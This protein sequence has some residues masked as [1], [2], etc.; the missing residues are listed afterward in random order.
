M[1]W[2]KSERREDPFSVL[3]LFAYTG[4][5]TIACGCRRGKRLPCGRGKGYG[6]LGKGKRAS[7]SGLEDTAHSLDCRRLRQICRAGDPPGAGATTRSSWTRRAMEEVRPARCGSSKKNLYPFVE[8]ASKVLSATTPLFVIINS[9]TT[10]LAPSVLGYI[11]DTLVSTSSYGGKTLLRRAGAS[12]DEYRVWRFRAAATGRWD[13]ER[14][15]RICTNGNL[16][17]T[18]LQI[19]LLRHG[20][21]EAEHVVFRRSES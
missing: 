4:G 16:Q 20:S 2:R 11:L 3:N 18:D 1:R 13:Q 10:G 8:L 7:S 14:T 19:C 15:E 5:A 9:Y 21:G 17:V 6:R 12:R